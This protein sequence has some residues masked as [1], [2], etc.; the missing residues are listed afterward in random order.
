M[1][2]LVVDRVIIIFNLCSNCFKTIAF[3][4]GDIFTEATR[5]VQ[6]EWNRGAGDQKGEHFRNIFS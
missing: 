6:G 3:G 2:S 4:E 5:H 1:I